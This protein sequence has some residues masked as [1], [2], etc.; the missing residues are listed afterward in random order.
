MYRTVLSQLINAEEFA[1]LTPEELRDLVLKLDE[2]IVFGTSEVIDPRAEA[3][4]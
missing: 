3:V 4:A 2:Q 1:S